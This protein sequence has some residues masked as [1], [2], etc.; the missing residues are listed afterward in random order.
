MDITR[1][2]GSLIHTEQVDIPTM[3][4]C[5]EPSVVLTRPSVV[6][7]RPSVVLT[8]PSVV[9]TR[10]SVVLTCWY[11]EW[12]ELTFIN[13]HMVLFDITSLAILWNVCCILCSDGGGD[14]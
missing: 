11:L 7:T 9:L 4:K 3:S 6:L 12:R 2:L 13:I 10:P 14:M 8:R 5:V 1:I